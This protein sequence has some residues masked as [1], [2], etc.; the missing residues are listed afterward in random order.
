MS[1]QESI[2]S[3]S[4]NDDKSIGKILYNLTIKS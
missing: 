1:M 2:T 4:E 3:V